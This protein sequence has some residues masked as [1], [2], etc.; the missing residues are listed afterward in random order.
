M[1]EEMLGLWQTT[2]RTIDT[3]LWLHAAIVLRGTLQ[4][5]RFILRDRDYPPADKLKW[6]VQAPG[7]NLARR[8]AVRLARQPALPDW[9]AWAMGRPRANRVANGA[10][11]AART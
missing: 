3:S 9:A 10:T 8:V 7:Y 6:L 11:P 4:D 2:G 5:W 1:Y